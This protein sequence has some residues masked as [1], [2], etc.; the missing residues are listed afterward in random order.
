M[1]IQ[2]LVQS[3]QGAFDSSRC[4]LTLPALRR[5]IERCCG[6]NG[7]APFLFCA[8]AWEEEEGTVFVFFW[9][10]EEEWLWY[11]G[12][13]YDEFQIPVHLKLLLKIKYFFFLLSFY[14]IS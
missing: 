13:V 11:G 14:D 5:R 3:L 9:G 1:F 10:C 7:A 8:G 6:I 4:V 2:E 12:K